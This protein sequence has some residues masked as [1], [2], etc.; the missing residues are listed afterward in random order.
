MGSCKRI[1]VHDHPG[2]QLKIGGKTNH[3]RERGSL[4][5]IERDTGRPVDR[6]LEGKIIRN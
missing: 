5:G 3:P 2:R 6:T 1:G 4:K